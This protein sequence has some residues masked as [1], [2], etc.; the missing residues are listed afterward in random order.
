MIPEQDKETFIKC[1]KW[2]GALEAKDSE[3]NKNHH[4]LLK[5][6]CGW[7]LQ[8]KEFQ[9]LMSVEDQKHLWIHGKPGR[10]SDTVGFGDCYLV[11]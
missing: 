10:C 2:L 5:G 8:T 1:R 4:L 3:Y 11:Q 9:A 7:I 6:T